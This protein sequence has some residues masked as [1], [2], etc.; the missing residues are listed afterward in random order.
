M[1]TDPSPKEPQ[2]YHHEN[3]IWQKFVLVLLLICVL[4]VIL[5]ICGFALDHYLSRRPWPF[6]SN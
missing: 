2:F 1:R 5:A 4:L 3:D 6:F